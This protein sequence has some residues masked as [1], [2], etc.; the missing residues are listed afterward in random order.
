[1]EVRAGGVPVVEV[2]GRYGVSRKTAQAWVRRYH[3]DGLQHKDEL[4]RFPSCQRSA[5][6]LG[7]GQHAAGSSS[8]LRI[9]AGRT[10]PSGG[11]AAV[12]PSVVT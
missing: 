11:G 9:F 2:A 1:M 6:N 7:Q 3:Q 12:P 8:T 10:V 4:R 5:L